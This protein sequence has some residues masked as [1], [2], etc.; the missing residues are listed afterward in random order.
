MT[1]WTGLT[2]DHPRGYRA[3]RAATRHPAA[4][5][6]DIRWDIQPLEGFESAPIAE[7]ARRYDLVVL[8]HP[9]I[10]EAIETGALQPLDALFTAAEL[11]AWRAA[12]VGLSARSYEMAGHLWALPLDAATQVSVRCDAGIPVP[13]TWA[14]AV[15][16]AGE[17]PAALPTAGPHLFLTLC[18]IA[19]GDGAT[20]GDGDTF[21]TEAEYGAAIDILRHF[22]SDRPVDGNDN[23]IALLE[24]MSGGDGPDY[25]PH[26]YGYVNYACRPRPLWFADAPSGT[27]GRHG[28]VLGGTGIAVSTRCVPDPTLLDHL[29]WLMT[30]DT[31]RRFVVAEEGQPAL[32]GA[33]DDDAVNA[34]SH[35][36]YRTTRAT[37]DD[38][39]V[40]PRHAGAI[41]FQNAGAAAVRACLFDHRDIS[42]L[43]REVNESYER[44]LAPATTSRTAS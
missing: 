19:V 33:W 22:V 27:A 17:I 4:P 31:Q 9:H 42:R 18:G 39:W 26:I 12:S 2:W 41:A 37:I 11:A 29:R 3:L 13:R 34:G 8:D 28:S 23:P 15:E 35:D 7:T 25:C 44:S 14:E 43:T 21:L 36:F 5:A 38:A 1:S 16:L 24:R 10:G 32:T 40:R 30:T 6:C 20:P